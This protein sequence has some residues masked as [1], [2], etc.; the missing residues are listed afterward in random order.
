MP[1]VDEAEAPSPPG[2]NAPPTDFRPE[3]GMTSQ[4]WNIAR[5]TAMAGNSY[6]PHPESRIIDWIFRTTGSTDW[7]GE[8]ITVLSASKTQIRAYHTPKKLRQVDGIVKR[9]TK[10]EADLLK[11]RVRLVRAADTRWRYLAHA[12]MTALGGGPQGQQVWTMSVGDAAMLLSQMQLYRGFEILYDASI[13]A[14]NGQNLHVEKVEPVDYIAGAERDGAVGVGFQPAVQKLEEGVWLTISPLLTYDGDALDLA[15]DL[16]TNVVR[17]LIRTSILTR[18]EIGPNDMTINV[19]EVSETR[20]NQPITNWPI[21]QTLVM[22]AGIVP[23]LLESKN[24]I[25][26]IPGTMPSDREL[27]VLLDAEIGGRFPEAPAGRTSRTNDE[28]D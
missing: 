8:K 25:L 27:L 18:R 24:G 5:Y 1:A 15:V 4:T 9:F 13:K 23:G 20:L 21:G 10:S 22:S 14:V 28:P 12:R 3:P 19:P 17:R 7:H 16:R 2:D 6:N 26:R 11:L